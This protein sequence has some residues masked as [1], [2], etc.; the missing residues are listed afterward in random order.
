MLPNDMGDTCTI[1]VRVTPRSPRRG[2]EV[3]DGRI[4]VRVQAPPAEGRAT[5][6]ARVTLAGALGVPRSA[7]RLRSGATARDKAFDVDGLSRG[8][9]LER[10]GG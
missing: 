6:E 8:A 2:V 1:A 7:V 10:L 5:E 4:L 9:A 3:R